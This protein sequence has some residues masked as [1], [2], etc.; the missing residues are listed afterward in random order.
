MSLQ[1]LDWLTRYLNRFEGALLGGT[2]G[3]WRR[4]VDLGSAVDYLLVLELTKNPD[5]YRGSTYLSK[6]VDPAPL[7]FGPGA[8]ARARDCA[9][10]A[11]PM[12]AH[13]RLPA[14]RAF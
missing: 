12:P 6:D 8:R 9:L 2:P 3:D 1:A 4:Y 7:A 10:V 5:A 14:S 13:A 11:L